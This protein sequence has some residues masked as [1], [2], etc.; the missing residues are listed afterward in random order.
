MMKKGTLVLLLFFLG[1]WCTGQTIDL[2][3]FQQEVAAK[4]ADESYESAMVLIEEVML[5]DESTSLELAYANYY[6]HLIYRKI[7]IFTE[8]LTYLNKAL[9]LGQKTGNKKQFE[10]QIKLDYALLALE[11]LDYTTSMERVE[12]IDPKGVGIVEGYQGIYTFLL[13][14]KEMEMNRDYAVALTQFE[15]AI[16]LLEK[17]QPAYL[18][19]L[20]KEKMRLHKY[21]GQDKEVMQSYQIGLALGEQYKR[22]VAVL[23]LHHVLMNYYKDKGLYQE[24]MAMSNVM[25]ALFMEFDAIGKSSRLNQ[26]VKELT[27]AKVEE[28]RLRDLRI[29]KILWSSLFLVGVLVLIALVVFTKNNRYK[30]VMER[31]NQLLRVDFQ[32]LHQQDSQQEKEDTQLLSERQVYILDLVKQGKKNKEIA[33]KLFISENT[34]KY[35]LKI[36]YETLQVKGRSD[37]LEETE[38][39]QKEHTIPTTHPRE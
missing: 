27:E 12:K 30:G 28:Q 31:E 23:E 11:Q 18:P 15:K 34:V 21:L 39:Q 1:L 38:Q 25:I 37:L 8:A 6:K 26:L 14:V 35:H 2:E 17:Q 5:N 13:A 16:Q 3:R 19:Y 4:Q 36:I 7:G 32:S 24:S 20:Y 29:Q 22:T 33:E 10:Q 9:V